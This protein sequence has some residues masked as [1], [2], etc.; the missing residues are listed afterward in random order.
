MNWLDLL[1]QAMPVLLTAVIIPL[2]LAIGRLI[3]KKLKTEMQQKY[4]EMAVNAVATA[5]SETMQTF[6]KSLKDS[7]TWN[8]ETAKQAFIMA[9][10][11]SIQIM[12]VAVL[13]AMPEIVRDFETW[14]T[15]QI[16]AT[17]LELKS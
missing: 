7:G 5:V 17:T 8:E 9:K 4:L 16:E 6:V 3:S 14:L 2:I 1:N 13:N 10:N 15:S 11:K 12:G